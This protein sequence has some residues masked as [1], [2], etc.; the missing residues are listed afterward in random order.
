[1]TME[2]SLTGRLISGTCPDH[3]LRWYLMSTI[4]IYFLKL[5]ILIRLVLLLIV[6]RLL[7]ILPLL[8]N[9]LISRMILLISPLDL[10][11]QVFPQEY[12][13][14]LNLKYLLDLISGRSC[15]LV[16]QL[17]HAGIYP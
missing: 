1:M 10:I 17:I 13:C 4:L 6:S 2:L 9:F 11:I 12:L 14:F 3:Y 7:K 8:I 5:N 16:L 15:V